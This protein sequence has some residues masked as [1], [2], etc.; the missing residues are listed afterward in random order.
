V[1]FRFKNLFLG[2]FAWIGLIGSFPDNSLKG[3][4]AGF[5]VA[6][7]FFRESCIAGSAG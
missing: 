3:S 6:L 1:S 7:T 5:S 2:S 4:S